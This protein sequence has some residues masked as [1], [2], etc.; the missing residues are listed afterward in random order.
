MIPKNRMQYCQSSQSQDKSKTRLIPL[1]SQQT[2]PFS[3]YCFPLLAYPGQATSYL[4]LRVYFVIKTAATLPRNGNRQ[5]SHS[6]LLFAYQESIKA[7]MSFSEVGMPPRSPNEFTKSSKGSS[8][9]ASVSSSNKSRKKSRTDSPSRS[10]IIDDGEAMENGRLPLGLVT[11]IWAPFG[12]F[13]SRKQSQQIAISSKREILL[14]QWKG[15]RQ[16][17]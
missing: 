17:R 16:V 2:E 15:I 4:F 3:C 5:S 12:V 6:L 14:S 13:S 9:S 8:A 10:S 1:S 7:T 11:P